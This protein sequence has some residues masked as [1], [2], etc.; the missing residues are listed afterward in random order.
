MADI[1]EISV[2]KKFSLVELLMIIMIVGIIFTI[3]VPLSMSNKNHKNMAEAIYNLQ[4]IAQK[5]VEFYNN[6][7]NGYYA[8]DVSMLNIDENQFKKTDGDFIFD[9]TLTD[10]TVVAT[11]NEKFGIEGA[12]ISY[13][14]PRGPWALGDDK[15]S[16]STFD[17][18]WLP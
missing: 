17:N 2:E 5:D 15:V 16:T 18:A 3:I 7:D 1:N 8:F 11:T 14:L 6:P 4:L 12:K 13:Y 9:Y 10:S